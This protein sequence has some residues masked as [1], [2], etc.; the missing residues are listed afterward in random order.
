MRHLIESASKLTEATQEQLNQMR[1]Y[2]QTLT[3]ALEMYPDM[4]SDIEPRLQRLRAFVQN[5][6]NTRT[7]GDPN[8]PRGDQTAPPGQPNTV[9]EIPARPDNTTGTVPPGQPN[10]VPDRQQINVPQAISQLRTLLQSDPRGQ[11]T[12][13][14]AQQLG[15]WLQNNPRN[16]SAGTVQ[17]LLQTYQQNTQAPGQT[18]VI[19][20][21]PAGRN[22]NAGDVEAGVANVPGSQNMAENKTINEASININGN[23]ASEVAEILR[24]MQLAGAPDAKVVGADDINPGPKPCPIC[25]K[26]H[27]PDPEPSGGCGM[28]SPEEPGM[29]DMIRMVS[30]E[31]EDYDG[32]FQDATTEPDED[33]TD[34]LNVITPS[35]DDLHRTKDMRAVRANDPAMEDLTA[36]LSAALAEK[37]KSK[38][39]KVSE[40]DDDPC[41]DDYEM[42]GMKTKNGKEVPN[43]VPKK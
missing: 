22:P 19:P 14:I 8:D 20:Q 1:Q 7:Q 29:G 39:E 6:A 43:C 24:M 10:T 27:G 32:D 23:D 21:I 9:P 28:D 31:E 15:T 16:P 2:I 34:D 18:N 41:W 3:Q 11:A 17:R 42:I 40:D 37:M 26:V 38:D 25:G 4:A 12:G 36:R 33:Y 13:R 5:D 30:K 35:G